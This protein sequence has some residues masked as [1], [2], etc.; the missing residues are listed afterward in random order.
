MT[1]AVDGLNFHESFL[2]AGGLGFRCLEAGRGET[3]LRLRANGEL[4][5]TE[6]DAI[7]AQERRLIAI[8]LPPAETERTLYA[9]VELTEALARER[10]SIIADSA[11]AEAALSLARAT[12]ERVQALVLLAP[13][14]TAGIETLLAAVEVPTLFMLG[15][16][17]EVTPPEAG[18]LFRARMP[19]C[20]LALVYDAGHELEADRPA[21]V[22]ALIA[23]FLERREIFV[24]SR[25]SSLINP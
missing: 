1:R 16:R 8:D 11:P 13:A 6:T 15:T 14:L 2:E 25:E 21:A 4:S 7:L 10:Y 19:N 24:V 18:R 5:V 12:G 20:S 9:L 22:A 17:D 3:V 23:D